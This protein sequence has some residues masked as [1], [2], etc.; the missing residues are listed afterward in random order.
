[1]KPN[2]I[3]LLI[4]F[5]GIIQGIILSV[6]LFSRS[7]GKAQSNLFLGCFIAA[8]ALYLST[9]GLQQL[10]GW[11][12]VWLT[13]PLTFVIGPLLY[14]YVLSFSRRVPAKEVLLHL[15]WAIIYYPVVYIYTTLMEPFV[16]NQFTVEQSPYNW[17]SF[18]IVIVKFG[19]LL[20]YYF[21]C[22]KA[23]RHHR[24]IITDNF[25]ETSR[26]DL[27]WVRRVANLYLV[28]V[29]ISI[30]L[31]VLTQQFP[32]RMYTISLFNLVLL[33]CFIYYVS[34]R[35]LLQPVLF[36]HRS[37]LIILHQ[38]PKS[39]TGGNAPEP[40]INN[41][42]R[43]AKPEKYQ[44]SSMEKAKQQEICDR[45]IDVLEK[46]KLFTE[47]ELTLQ[48]LADQ[49][50]FPPYQVSQSLNECLGKSFYDLVNGYRLE[51]AKR[52]LLDPSKSNLTILS[53]GFEAGFNSKTTFNTVFKQKTGLTPT[54]FRK[55]KELVVNPL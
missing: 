2:N 50:K 31:Y 23:L 5:L 44:R 21:L 13:D 17:F 45:A 33:S 40:E 22:R 53:I 52:L 18:L 24:Q 36:R 3:L 20:L 30:F 41:E 55:Q 7:K 54:A 51:E 4:T 37:E 49:I 29:I 8:I 11:K 48:E 46:E 43:N 15:C 10:W 1:M 32:T 38:D 12:F 26:I 28:L 42:V 16:N 19:Q 9:P 47:P 6:L 25:S 39:E 27:L 35:G 34:I 14:L